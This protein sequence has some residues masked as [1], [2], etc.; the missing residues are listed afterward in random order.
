MQKK[1]RTQVWVFAVIAIFLS[2]VANSEDTWDTFNYYFYDQPPIIGTLVKKASCQPLK[3]YFT[4]EQIPF[5]NITMEHCEYESITKQGRFKDSYDRIQLVNQKNK[6]KKILY[7]NFA[8]C[9]ECRVEV[10]QIEL[11]QNQPPFVVFL[12]SWGGGSHGGTTYHVAL[13]DSETLSGKGEFV[14]GAFGDDR[15]FLDPND[16]FIRPENIKDIDGDGNRE[17]LTSEIICDPKT[18]I[19]GIHGFSYS[20]QDGR[21]VKKPF[22]T[23]QSKAEN[24]RYQPLM[25]EK[26]KLEAKAAK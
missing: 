5:V 19:C 26:Q 2:S 8:Y 6:M 16:D 4:K 24:A 18:P 14:F 25:K 15:L 11:V 17:I 23:E 21:Y 7:S 1:S 12:Q 13:F 3:D 9:V 22:E 10:R 20:Y